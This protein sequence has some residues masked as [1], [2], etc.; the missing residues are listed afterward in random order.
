MH[1]GVRT[2]LPIAGTILTLSRC[3]ALAATQQ[4]VRIHQ[5][6]LRFDH[7]RLARFLTA[8]HLVLSATHGIALAQLPNQPATGCATTRCSSHEC[9]RPLAWTSE[10]ARSDCGAGGTSDFARVA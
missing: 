3:E 9:C 4:L 6:R 2:A 8:E 5:G 1:S 7:E 10:I